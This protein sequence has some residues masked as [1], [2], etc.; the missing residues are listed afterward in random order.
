MGKFNQLFWIDTKLFD[1]A[2][3]AISLKRLPYYMKN[4]NLLKK[5]SGLKKAK[6]NDICYILGLGP[7]LKEVDL[8]K[9]E[10]D[11]ITVNNFYR[12]NNVDVKPNIYCIMDDIDYLSEESTTISDATKMY[13]EAYFVLN[14][15]YKKQAEKRI[16][17]D[18]K[19]IYLFAWRGYFNDRKKINIC[20]ISPIMGNIVCYAI[21]I[22]MYMEYKKIILLGCDFNSFAFRKEMHCYQ[23]D[24]E[25]EMSLSYELFCY[26]FC[27]D[28]HSKLYKYAR[29]NKIDIIN[30]TR[31]SLLDAYPFSDSI[32]KYY[33]VNS[34][35]DKFNA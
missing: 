26:S 21:Y 33:F 23:E 10:G 24:K 5:N 7:S 28:T 9:L 20:K 27:A 3:V 30:A 15:K 18:V 32:H 22:A 16:S 6:R 17:G 12:I 34:K 1:L 31:C 13:P 29:K 2:G 25:K 19:R 11:V 8:S 4:K 35:E 14:G